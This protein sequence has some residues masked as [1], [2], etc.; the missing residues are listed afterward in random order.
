MNTFL[1]RSLICSVL[2]A[3]LGI[4]TQA[5]AANT[6]P[7]LYVGADLGTSLANRHVAGIDGALGYQGVGISSGNSDKQ[8]T[9]YGLTLGYRINPYLAVEGGYVNLG[10]MGYQANTASGSVVGSAKSQGFTAAAVGILPLAHDVSVYGK[11]GLINAR[12]DLR[13]TGSAGI[14][15]SNTREYSVTPLIGLGASYDITPKVS[16][17]V[18]WNRYDKLGGASTSEVSYN[19]FSV[20]MRYKF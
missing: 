6:A 4:A 1:P 15:T 17:Q 13:A 12:T 18:E 10:S 19:T 20:G 14:A 9:T 8:D 3:S 5:H 11:L 16:T 7:G 2:V